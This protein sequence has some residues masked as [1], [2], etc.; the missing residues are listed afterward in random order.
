MAAVLLDTTVLIDALRGR[1]AADRLRSMRRVGD[2]AYTCAISVEELARGLHPGEE[3]MLACLLNGLR[4]A[5]LGRREGELAGTWRRSFSDRG[6]TLSQADC[7][8]AA[9]AAA[10]GARLATGNV[11]D[12]PMEDVVVDHWPSGI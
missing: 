9:A 12:F 1:G 5:P 11:R 3:K 10:M 2:M 8:I 6:I 7:L 4:M